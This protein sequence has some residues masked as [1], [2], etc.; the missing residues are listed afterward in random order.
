MRRHPEIGHA[1]LQAGDVPSTALDVCLHHHEKVDGSGYPFGL[2]GDDI[3]LAARMGAIC[4][5][6]DAL[7]SERAYKDASSPVAAVAAMASWS[8][9]F[10]PA[11]LFVFMKSICVFPVGMLIRL[12]SG[13]LAMMRDNGRRTSRA[14]LTVFYDIADQRLLPP[15]EVY[16]SDIDTSATIL[17]VPDPLHYGLANWAEVKE[18]LLEGHDPSI[19]S[20]ARPKLG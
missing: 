17:D 12:R 8:G 7:T 20:G 10:D 16:L 11:L 9:H 13:H 19:G 2:V 3:S 4:D 15:Y 5:V 14:R 18:Q 6:Y 1:L